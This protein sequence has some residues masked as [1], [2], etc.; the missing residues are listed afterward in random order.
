MEGSTI[1]C[2]NPQSVVD[3][4]KILVDNHNVKYIFFID[5]VFNDDQGCYLDLIRLMKKQGV[6]IPWTAFFKPEHIDD[7][8]IELMK[9]TGF[10]AAEIGAD[11]STDT[12]LGKLGKS[13]LF[14]DIIECNRQF[15]R[16]GIATAHFYMFGSPGET[17]KTVLE[18]IE[19]IKNLEKTVSFMFMGIRILPNTLL[20][21]RAIKEKIISES[22]NL[23]KPVYYLA[24]GLDKNWLEKTLTDG[25][26]K[27]RHC[28]FPPDALDSSLQFLHKLGYSGS[29][30]NMLL[31]NKKRIK[32]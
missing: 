15:V 29:M 24:P 22:E 5:S 8:K 20:S 1:R 2:R 10:K 28:V 4:I 25:F 18:G 9:Q 17:K 31:S 3:D 14:K 32:K 12:T 11:A 30:W 26:A 7:Q 6:N 21:K 16:H 23:L 27:T 19:N 13:F